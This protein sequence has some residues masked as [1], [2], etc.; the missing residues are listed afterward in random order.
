[1][2]HAGR[3]GRATAQAF[4]ALHHAHV[5]EISTNLAVLYLGMPGEFGSLLA[6]HLGGPRGE[7]WFAGHTRGAAQEMTRLRDERLAAV[8]MSLIHL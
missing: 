8:H 5:A 6:T 2:L 3:M 4:R 7:L 1:M